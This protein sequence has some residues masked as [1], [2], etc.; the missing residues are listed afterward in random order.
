MQYCEMYFEVLVP[1]WMNVVPIDFYGVRRDP[2]S[3]EAWG[4]GSLRNACAE[5]F[6]EALL[7]CDSGLAGYPA[8][9]IR[10]VSLI[11]LLLLLFGKA[12]GATSEAVVIS[13]EPESRKVL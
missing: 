5:D 12:N 1:R 6:V 4:W 10:Y 11:A 9:I 7:S 8:A 13:S 3:T 2:P